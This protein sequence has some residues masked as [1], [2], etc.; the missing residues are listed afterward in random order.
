M[1]DFF[2]T[3]YLGMGVACFA[4]VIIGYGLHS[5]IGG[6]GPVGAVYDAC[7]EQE[8]DDARVMRLLEQC[9]L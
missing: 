9:D 6:D 5:L 7:E 8:S 3:Y 2:W 4:G 1:F